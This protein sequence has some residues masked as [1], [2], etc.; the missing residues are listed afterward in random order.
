MVKKIFIL[1][2]VLF[3]TGLT[4]TFAGEAAK[5][6]SKAQSQRIFHYLNANYPS[7]MTE[8]KSLMKSNPTAARQKL[9]A[10]LGKGEA[11][12]KKDKL[13][14]ETLVKEYR[15]N[16]DR[17]V[18]GKIKVILVKNYQLKIKYKKRVI[19]NVEVAL[20]KAKNDLENFEANQ[21]VAISKALEQLQKSSK[22]K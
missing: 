5:R 18:L 3:I 17:A 9:N 22:K 12:L 21:N 13:E 10:L 8:I 20:L 11:A 2:V 6:A 16:N 19:T 4:G 7:E 1:L 15:K 14:L